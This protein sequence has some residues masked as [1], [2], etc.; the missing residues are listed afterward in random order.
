MDGC[1]NVQ[2]FA[3][4]AMFLLVTHKSLLLN[5]NS[6]NLAMLP[7][8]REQGVQEPKR[9]HWPHLT[10]GLVF[11]LLTRVQ[12]GCSAHVEKLKTLN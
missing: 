2:S 11:I 1:Q 9:R 4:Q 6:K 10:L 3:M 12:T 7:Y 5:G 8:A